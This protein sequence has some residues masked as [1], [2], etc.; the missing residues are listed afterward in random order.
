MDRTRWAALGTVIVV[1][2]LAGAAFALTS[3]GRTASSAPVVS[4]TSAPT[5]TAAPTTTT[6]FTTT[7]APPS[8]DLA[9]GAENPR[10]ADL[11]R[12]LKEL[13]FDPGPAD[14]VFGLA[15]HYAV[16]GFQKLAGMQPSGV[17]TPAV[18]SALETAAPPTAKVPNGGADRVEI[19][20]PSQLLFVY[21]AGNLRLITHISTGSGKSYCENGHCGNARTPAGS[22]RFSYR[23]SG[24]RVSP[25]G[26]L[27]N[28]VYFTSTG[29]AV[30]GSNS[31]PT[32]PASH[33][34]V[35]IPM[36]IAAYFPSLVERGDAVYVLD[37]GAAPAPAAPLPAVLP[38]PPNDPPSPPEGTE[39]T[40]APEP[41]TT[42]LPPDTTTTTTATQP[43]PPVP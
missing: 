5:T 24:W 25:L 36:H 39:T 18:W 43:P 42:T 3:D 29:I 35:R 28:P 7:T 19:D 37:G 6:A 9:R 16:Q 40:L 34:C 11:Q 31:V 14:G 32:Y 4:S 10:V 8:T 1:V 23:F 12:R 38:P 17:V 13:R 20:L 26:R 30:H 15:T 22:F 41:T 33:G 27:Y 21:Q 2:A